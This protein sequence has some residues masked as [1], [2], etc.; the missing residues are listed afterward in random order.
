VGTI[1]TVTIGG[2]NVTGASHTLQFFQDSTFV[3][4]FVSEVSFND[5]V[6]AVPEPSSWAM[7]LAGMRAVGL[8]LRRSRRIAVSFGCLD[9][10]W[11]AG[12]C[13]LWP[14]PAPILCCRPR[15]PCF[16]ALHCTAAGAEPGDLE[17]IARADEGRWS[18]ET[19]NLNLY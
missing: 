14:P 3:W 7:L 13:R 17:A 1:G 18:A 9:A 4:T 19:G 5:D 8:A 10:V 16:N 12:D 15:S 11:R 2:L 6:P